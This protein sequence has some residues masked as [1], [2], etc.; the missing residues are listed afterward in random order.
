MTQD[1]KTEFY[2][3]LGRVFEIYRL[4][5]TE[6]VGQMWWLALEPYAMD[7]V[8]AGFNL[9]L[10]DINAGKFAPTPAHILEQMTEKTS[11]LAILAWSSVLMAIRLG[12]AGA[13]LTFEDRNILD[14]IKK[15]GGWRLLCHCL[16]RDLAFKQREF[17]KCY[18][19]RLAFLHLKYLLVLTTSPCPHFLWGCLH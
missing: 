2:D 11:E 3:I 4:P 16:E 5:A 9:H 13:S 19:Q 7:R 15:I 17:I 10:K 14:V 1:D 12:G 8:R 18:D 6:E